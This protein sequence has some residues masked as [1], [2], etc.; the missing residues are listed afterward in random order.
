MP[1][2]K[3]LANQRRFAR[4]ARAR[5]KGRKKSKSKRRR[6]VR[7][8]IR[9]TTR[10][11]RNMARRSRR[12]SRRGKSLR[13]PVVGTLLGLWMAHEATQGASTSLITGQ[14]N[15]AGG[16]LRSALQSPQVSASRAL[17]PAG[18][19]LLYSFARRAIKPGVRVGPV[20][21]EA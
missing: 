17:G 16:Q 2:A 20:R 21:I 7:R 3:Q 9:R 19:L 14:F 4:M 11:V 15:Q 8:V 6:S 12:G 5:A 10:K 18:M 1:T 13:I